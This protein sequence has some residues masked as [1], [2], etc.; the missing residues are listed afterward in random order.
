MTIGALV[1]CGALILFGIITWYLVMA[2]KQAQRTAH[3]M[4]QLLIST[5]PGVEAAVGDLRSLLSRADRLMAGAEQGTGGIAS[6]FRAV[7]QAAAGW[8]AGASEP[9]SR[10]GQF[11]SFG[12]ALALAISRMW[13]AFTPAHDQPAEPAAEGAHH[14]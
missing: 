12:T 3:A 5:R 4:E 11:V 9:S 14:G 6:L 13:S 1:G 10:I 2:L 8:R 7:G